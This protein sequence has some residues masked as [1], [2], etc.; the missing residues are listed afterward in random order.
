[1]IIINELV[2]SH[3]TSSNEVPRNERKLLLLTLQHIFVSNALM[4]HL[5]MSDVDQLI[6]I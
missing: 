1:M 2:S 5:I 3:K 6:L 4:T